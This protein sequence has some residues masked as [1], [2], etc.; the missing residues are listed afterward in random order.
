MDD[1]YVA[2]RGCPL[3][4]PSSKSQHSCATEA[5]TVSA[6]NMH[7]DFCPSEKD[8]IKTTDEIKPHLLHII[9]TSEPQRR[10]NCCLPSRGAS[11]YTN[12]RNG[13]ISLLTFMTY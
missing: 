9:A 10:T 4:S 7:K 3:S 13:M 12:P 8:K 1:S 11:A 5:T 6:L 2:K